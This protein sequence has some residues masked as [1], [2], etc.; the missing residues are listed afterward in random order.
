M[1]AWSDDGSVENVGIKSD[2]MVGHKFRRVCRE[3][4]GVDW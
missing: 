2:D 1:W 4:I 3:K